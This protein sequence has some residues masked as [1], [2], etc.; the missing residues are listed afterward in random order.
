VLEVKRLHIGYSKALFEEPISGHWKKGAVVILLGDN[1]VGKS[2]FLKTLAELIDPIAGEV[3]L[4]SE[5]IGW[6]DSSISK[7]VYLSVHDFLSFGINS[8]LEEKKEW[9]EK[10]DLT[11]QLDRFLDEL[12]DGQ[13]RKLCIIRQLLKKPEILFL[14]E[15]TVYLDVKSKSRLAQIIRELKKNTLIFCSTHDMHFSEEIGTEKIE[16]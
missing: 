9:L 13:F 2:T 4:N 14:D 11:I 6:V 15:P 1:G 5:S 10:F 3:H 12:S 7:G 16:F 8:S